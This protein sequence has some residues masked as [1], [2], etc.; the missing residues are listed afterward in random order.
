MIKLSIGR[1]RQYK[2]PRL[3]KIEAN[4][5]GY[6]AG[7]L[8]LRNVSVYQHRK[9]DPRSHETEDGVV[10]VEQEYEETTKE[11]EQGKVQQGG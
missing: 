2:R 8:A 4:N 11:E 7:R 5:R 1:L 3:A 9:P 6:R 10:N